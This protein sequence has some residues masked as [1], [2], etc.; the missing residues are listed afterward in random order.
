MGN[1]LN[2]EK[3]KEDK[4]QTIQWKKFWG[5]LWRLLQPFRKYF[6]FIGFIILVTSILDLVN[7]YLL[8]LLIDGL[9]GFRP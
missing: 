8:K 6:A 5:E 3:E 2:S 7:P 4:K 1:S 9:N